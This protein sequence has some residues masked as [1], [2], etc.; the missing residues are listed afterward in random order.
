ML[1]GFCAVLPHPANYEKRCWRFHRVVVLPDYQ[2]LGIGTKLLDFI[3]EMYHKE[4]K[5]I[6]LKTSHI[7]FIN[8]CFSSESWECISNT[9]Q[10][11]RFDWK[12]KCDTK[13]DSKYKKRITESFVYIGKPT[14]KPKRNLEV[15]KGFRVSLEDLERL[16]EKY[17]LTV[18]TGEFK[19]NTDFENL[20]THLGIR[21]KTLYIHSG[22]RT[23]SNQVPENEYTLQGEIDLW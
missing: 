7:R 9:K 14:G 2:G 20:C 23:V 1:V 19:F 13:I 18:Y 17:D 21:T 8:H 16:K 22:K 5:T 6:Y 4:V 3:A 10:G 11:K 15:P 12:N